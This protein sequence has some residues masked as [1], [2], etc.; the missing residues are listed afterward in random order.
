MSLIVRSLGFIGLTT[1]FVFYLNSVQGL[2][3]LARY[4]IQAGFL[5]LVTL[6]FE[7][8]FNFI[9]LRYGVL[10]YPGGV[11]MPFKLGVTLYISLSTFLHIVIPFSTLEG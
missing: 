2:F 6:F 1:V 5:F 4:E 11:Y 9:S 3:W 8:L 10:G 7:I